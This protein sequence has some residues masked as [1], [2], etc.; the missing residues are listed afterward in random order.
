MSGQQ[1]WRLQWLRIVTLQEL[2]IVRVRR[3]AIN[4]GFLT[5]AAFADRRLESLVYQFL[6]SVLV[7]C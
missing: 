1:A 5:H 2:L 3:V 4:N 6:Y 7:A